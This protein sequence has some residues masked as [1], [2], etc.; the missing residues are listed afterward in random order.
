LSWRP[1]PVDRY[2]PLNCSNSIDNSVFE[3]E[4]HGKAFCHQ[5]EP[6][7]SATTFM[8]EIGTATLL[9]LKRILQ[10]MPMLILRGKSFYHPIVERHWDCFYKAG[11]KTPILHFEITT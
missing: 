9:S 4:Q 10:L 2:V 3:F 7:L 8:S 1:K 11:V 5:P 6:P